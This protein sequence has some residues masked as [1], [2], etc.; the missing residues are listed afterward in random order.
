MP[1][2]DN[3][4]PLT[5]GVAA[6]HGVDRPADSSA[7]RAEASARIPLEVEQVD[8]LDRLETLAGELDTLLGR[9]G[10]PASARWPELRAG[11]AHDP[12]ARPRAVVVRRA[13]SPVAVALL[14]AR[15]RNGA[16]ILHGV[17]QDD[18]E[19]W[20]AALDDEAAEA[21]AAALTAA[22]LNLHRPWM[23]D[24]RMQPTDDPVI[25]ALH[26]MLPC[27]VIIPGVE[28]AKLACDTS[29]SLARCLSRNTR[30][31]CARARKRIAAAGLR[32]ILEWTRE[33]AVIERHLDEVV[34]LHRRR[35]HQL[36]GFAGLDDPRQREHFKDTV[37]LQ[38]GAGRARL[39]TFRLDGQLAAFALCFE[40]AGQLLV[41]SNMASPDWLDF[42]PGTIANAEIVAAA[43]RD[44][45]VREVDWGP[46][47]Q[48]YK[49]SGEGVRVEQLVQFN[50]WSSVSFRMVWSI[51][52]R[53]RR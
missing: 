25:A 48:R 37:R 41:Y 2:P 21:L 32:P 35:N 20:L 27:S 52:E 23:L 7:R 30:N 46:G 36:R 53:V 38:A 16:W 42:S 33:A 1:V 11:L 12:Q 17:N 13:N 44:P 29:R 5:A 45:S 40:S 15:L 39:L 9:T 43:H 14:T 22:L 6:A 4:P 10:A 34:T 24:L 50:A 26:R 31:A 18:S 49:L 8:Q 28:V 47:L 19:G 51:V 3:D